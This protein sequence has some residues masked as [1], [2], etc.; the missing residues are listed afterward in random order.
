MNKKYTRH[1]RASNSRLETIAA[2][3][4]V[5]DQIYSCLK[6]LHLEQSHLVIA[7]QVQIHFRGFAICFFAFFTIN[8]LKHFLFLFFF[9]FTV[10][11]VIRAADF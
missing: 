6:V 9:L 5:V 11:L 4:S 2:G 7:T 8:T 1:D 3:V 10:Y